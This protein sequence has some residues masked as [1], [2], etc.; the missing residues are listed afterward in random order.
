[1]QIG[2]RVLLSVSVVAMLPFTASAKF[3]SA[4]PVRFTEGGVNHFNLYAYSYN[5]PIN[6]RDPD[7]RR[8]RQIQLPGGKRVLHF[9]LNVQRANRTDGSPVSESIQRSRLQTSLNDFN[10]IVNSA[11]PNSFV[12]GGIV[13]NDGPI[14]S[15]FVDNVTF[16]NEVGALDFNPETQTLRLTDSDNGKQ[17]QFMRRDTP[18]HELGHAGGLDHPNPRQN[19]NLMSG[20]ERGISPDRDTLTPE[21]VDQLFEFDGNYEFD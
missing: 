15:E 5:D 16:G 20:A 11:D 6:S 3:L 2:L 17:S 7:G 8:P 19:G 1:M 12:T 10:D 18:T 21:Q 13:F 4:D 9:T 14:D